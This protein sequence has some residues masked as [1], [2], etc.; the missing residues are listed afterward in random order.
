MT[1]VARRASFLVVFLLV[2]VAILSGN[3]LAGSISISPLRQELE[4]AP[5]QAF[6]SRLQVHN[7]SPR[8]STIHLSAESFGVVNEYYDYSFTQSGDLKKWLKFDKPELVLGPNSSGSA[9]YTLGIPNDAEPGEKYIALFASVDSK[10]SNDSV[11]SIDRVGLLLY[12]TIAGNVSKRANVVHARIPPLTFTHNP[13]WNIRLNSTGTA[14]FRSKIT[15]AVTNVFGKTVS[16]NKQDHLILPNTVRFI[17]NSVN[18]GRVPGIYKVSFLIGRGDDPAYKLTKWVVYLPLW[19]IILLAV[20][21][22]LATRK[23]KNKGKDT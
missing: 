1:V 22:T 3:L 13:K 7:S 10:S 20:V 5:G 23:T 12:I 4:L 18:L 16:N 2:F 17:E 21:L 19:S 8:S 9:N 15:T 6:T 11:N 14:H